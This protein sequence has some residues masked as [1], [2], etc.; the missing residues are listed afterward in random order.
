MS[1]N[2]NIFFDEWQACLRAHY[3]HVIRTNDTITEPTLRS[4][5]L[6]TGLSED[7]LAALREEALGALGEAY[8]AVESVEAAEDTP[9]APVEAPQP[10][11]YDLP[12]ADLTLDTAPPEDEAEPVAPAEMGTDLAPVEPEVA[13][14][15]EY[16]ESTADPVEADEGA[17]PDDDPD[18]YTPPP[19][20][21]SLF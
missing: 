9:L 10:D 2:G 4:V 18:P 1:P 7:E 3:I 5:L 12:Q 20:Q 13:L 17:L 6:A 15:P 14:P 19:N 16:A 11:D 8:E 21:L